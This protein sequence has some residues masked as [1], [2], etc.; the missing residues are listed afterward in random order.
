MGKIANGLYPESIKVKRL[1]M[2]SL[3]GLHIPVSMTG[4]ENSVK[5][6]CKFYFPAIETA[7][8]RYIPKTLSS[9]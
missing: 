3:Q 4:A 1:P 7:C 5:D 9:K 2:N 8:E 6:L